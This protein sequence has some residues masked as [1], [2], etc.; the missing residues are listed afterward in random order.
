MTYRRVQA[1][2]PGGAAVAYPMKIVKTTTESEMA[3]AVSDENS[4]ESWSFHSGLPNEIY[5]YYDSDV[6]DSDGNI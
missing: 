2:S 3:D 4:V 5:T 6:F 1:G